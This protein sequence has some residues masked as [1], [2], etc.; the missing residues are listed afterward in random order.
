[1]SAYLTNAIGVAIMTLVLTLASLIAVGSYR[2]LQREHFKDGFVGIMVLFLIL[3][4]ASVF[5]RNLFVAV[6]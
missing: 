2:L 5:S 6:P 3:L 4:I 1:M